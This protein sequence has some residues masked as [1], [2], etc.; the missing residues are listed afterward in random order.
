M[1]KRNISINAIHYRLTPKGL[2]QM[3]DQEAVVKRVEETFEK[4][5]RKDLQLA[6]KFEK[7]HPAFSDIFKDF[8]CMYAGHYRRINVA[9]HRIDLFNDEVRPVH[10]AQYRAG[11][12]E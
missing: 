11:Q 5:P 7:H 3:R 8:Q 9:K 6:A 10:S 12:T 2:D 4:D 1:N